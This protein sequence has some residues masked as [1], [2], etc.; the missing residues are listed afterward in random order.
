MANG[1]AVITVKITLAW[2]LCWYL[3]GVVLMCWITG[4]LPDEGRLRYWI[5]RGLKAKVG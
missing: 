5:V 4:S 1:S 2:W 3:A